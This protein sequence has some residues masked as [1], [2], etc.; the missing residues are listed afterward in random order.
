MQEARPRGLRGRP[1]RRRRE[2]PRRREGE[3]REGGGGDRPPLPRPRLPDDPLPRRRRKR[4]RADRRLRR[5]GRDGE[6]RLGPPE[7]L[8][9]PPDPPYEPLSRGLAAFRE[10]RW[11]EAHEEW[12]GAWKTAVD[13]DRRRLQ[14]LIQVAATAL[15]L[16]AGRRA[17]AERLLARALSKLEDAPDDVGGLPARRIRDGAVRVATVLATGEDLRAALDDLRRLRT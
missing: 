13:P 15:H 5:R 14:G 9:I 1:R 12:E 16:E 3:R 7:G 11:F 2:G 17:P 6:D 10:G 8:T 4:R